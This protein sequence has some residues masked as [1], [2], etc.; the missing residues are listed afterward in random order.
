[1]KNI[2]DRSPN[3]SKYLK[4]YGKLKKNESGLLPSIKPEISPSEKKKIKNE[5][6]IDSISLTPKNNDEEV[7]IILA[8]GIP[9]KA[10]LSP[11][12][13]IKDEEVIPRN[14][15]VIKKLAGGEVLARVSK[16][17]ISGLSEAG[18]NIVSNEEISA[19]PNF[20]DSSRA[21]DNSNKAFFRSMAEVTN[22]KSAD[23]F[24]WKSATGKGVSIAILDTGVAPHPDIKDKIVAFKDFVNGRDEA[25]DDNGH[26]SHVAGDAAGTGEISGGKY[27][28]TA[29][30]A[31]IVGVKVLRS[32]G[33]AKV[34]DIIEGMDWVIKNRD[35][36]N[37]RVIN[38]SLGIPSS[39]FRDNLIHKAVERAT[40]AGIVVVAAAGNEGPKM[41]TIGSAPGNSPL[42]LTV[43]ALD[44][45]NTPEKDDD[46]IASFS[47]MGPTADGLM[48]PDIV[49][50]GVDIISLNIKG[51]QTDKIAKA[52]DYLNKLDDEK[53][54]DLPEGL[55][56]GL[57][58]NPDTIMEK[59]PA[60]IR[61]YLNIHLPKFKYI[62]EYYVS[63]PGS[64]MSAPLTAGVIADMLEVNPTLSPDQVKDILKKTADDM[65]E[66]R[67]AQGAGSLDPMEAINVAVKTKGALPSSFAENKFGVGYLISGSGGN[68]PSR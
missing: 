21:G 65:G 60:E 68:N 10:V 58:L 51:S 42:A 23:K 25:Y 17:D 33:S 39:S 43:G 18:Y 27:K 67:I 6:N 13:G 53:L 28:G 12:M 49:A 41:G 29:P 14:V 22:V 59:S 1:M 34:S 52:V 31:N 38:M 45:K 54:K 61:K 46:T 62:N 19:L 11:G 55:Y 47:S 15:G 26:G 20:I 4:A 3:T 7:E 63:M 44:D 24:D 48:K 9:Q 35:K 36:Y 5:V 56:E 50:P 64:S 37:I 40:K 2:S 66:K 30:D 8:K 57:G 16:K 32:N